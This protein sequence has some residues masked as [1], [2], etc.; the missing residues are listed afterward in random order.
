[1]AAKHARITLTPGGHG[2]TIE[3][4]GQRLTGVRGISIRANV[5]EIPQ[6]DLDL[7]MQEAEIDGEV[8]VS[9][10]DKTRDTLIALGWTPPDPPA[11]GEEGLNSLRTGATVMVAGRRYVIRKRL[12][13][14][15]GGGMPIHMELVL[16]PEPDQT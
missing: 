3:V 8:F 5:H 9:V 2:S 14:Y 11:P 12:H 1:M 7:R 13:D 16:Y 6:L 4:D 10:P 15:P